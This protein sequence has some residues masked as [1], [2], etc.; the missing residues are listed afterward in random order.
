MAY[1]SKV[2]R[3]RVSA[4]NPRALAVCQRCGEWWNRDQLT[5]QFDWKGAQLANLYIL[6]CRHCYDVPQE[7]LR[8]IT[9]PADPT[10]I[11]YPSVE[12]FV[13]DSTE[14]RSVSY[15]QVTDPTTGIPIPSEVL[16]I[17]QDCA[18][19]TIEPYGN[20]TGL[21]QNAV[22]PLQ[23]VNGVPTH[24]GRVL[25]VLSI[26]SVGTVVSVTCSSVHGLQPDNQ[27]SIE[28]LTSGN[29]FFSV[30]VPTATMF[31]Y[32]TT[33]AVA[34]ALTSTTRIVTV[35]VGIPYSYVDIPEP[36]G[37]LS[38]LPSGGGGGPSPPA[39]IPGPPLDV[40]AS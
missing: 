35:N 30:Q 1:A 26:S 40:V 29:G 24:Y 18:N 3:A 33:Q 14:Y 39:T 10:P 38:G 12:D 34:P 16:R 7:Q 23:I 6:V 36:Y 32:T 8:A 17:T 31:Q 28:G 13:G 19:R 22:M 11:F 20:P 15:P 37:L 2:G 25:P 5:F 27:V 9:L 21:D 4:R